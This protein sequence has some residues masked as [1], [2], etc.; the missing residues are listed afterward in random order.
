MAHYATDCWDAEIK[1]SYGWIECVGHA[2][3]AC[4]DLEVHSTRSKVAME[5]QETLETPVVIS[6]TRAVLD[7]SKAGKLLR[8]DMPA[9]VEH[10]QGL[11]AKQVLEL[12]QSLQNGAVKIQCEGKE[13]TINS[14]LVS[15]KTEER[16]E[17]VR[18]FT[19]SVIEPSFGVGRI[20]YSLLEHS[21]Y[22]RPGTDDNTT[23]AVLRLPPMIAPIKVSILPIGSS[24]HFERISQ[25]LGAELLSFNLPSKCDS[26]SVSIGKKYARSDELGTPFAITIDFE[27]AEDQSVTVRERDSCDQIR[28]QTDVASWVIARLCSGALTWESALKEFPQFLVHDDDEHE[29]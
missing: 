3:R 2:D 4:Y 14:D 18:R 28:V 25:Q 20:L 15:V 12:Q 8:N 11:T 21:Y 26:S 24:D 17:S 5:A 9:V 22:V 1:S 10:L 29:V 27:S 13:I 16:R 6:E 23:R 19:P 7:K